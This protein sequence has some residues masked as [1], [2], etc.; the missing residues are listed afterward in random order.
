[1]IE[2][3]SDKSNPQQPT[4]LTRSVQLLDSPGPGAKDLVFTFRMIRLGCASPSESLR[5]VLLETQGS[6]TKDR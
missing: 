5:D 4:A 3:R 2:Y 1:M 6:S